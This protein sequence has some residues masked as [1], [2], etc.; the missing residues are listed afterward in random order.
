MLVNFSDGKLSSNGRRKMI[1][2]NDHEIALDMEEKLEPWTSYGNVVRYAMDFIKN[3]PIDKRNNLAWYLQYSCFWTDPLRPAIWPDNPAGKFAWAMTTLTKYFPYSG[4]KSFIDIVRQMLDRLWEYRTPDHFEWKDV[5]YASAHPGTGIYFGSRADG[6]F[7]TECDK[8]AQVGRA[9]VD[10]YE[11]SGEECYLQIG[12]HCADELVRHLRSGNESQSPLP[13]RVD[14]RSGKIIEEYT[15]DMIQP[16]RLF[17]ALIDLGYTTYQPY[18]EHIWD[19]IV[20]NPIQNN[21]WKGYFED[22]RI[23]PENANRDQLSALETARYIMENTAKFSDWQAIARNLIEWVKGTLGGHSFFTAIPIH[24]QKF[25]YYPMGSHTARF[26]SLCCMYAALSGEENYKEM[27][28]RSLNWATYMANENGLVTVGIDRP[29][30]YNQCWFTDGYFDYVPHFLHAM[31][32]VP[33]KAPFNEDHLLYSTSVVQDIQYQPLSIRYRIFQPNS[34]QKFR[35]TYLP[36]T[37][38]VDG[39][40]IPQQEITPDRASWVV[41]SEDLKVIQIQPFGREIT[42]LGRVES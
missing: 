2:I 17:E 29:D 33:E 32:F 16:V 12:I 7:V 15:A 14:V 4:D 41:E 24:E 34:K 8:I 36:V 18:L 13:F 30:Y 37:V 22:I 10:F 27:G 23:D 31:A 11:L 21:V 9:Y 25:C 19:W 20:Q 5:P 38:Q 42:I 3:C 39:K 28:I 1:Y 35:L 26:G 40:E 6:E